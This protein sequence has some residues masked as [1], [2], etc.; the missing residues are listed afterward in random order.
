MSQIIKLNKLIFRKL[1]HKRIYDWHELLSVIITIFLLLLNLCISVKPVSFRQALAYSCSSSAWK[2]M[3]LITLQKIWNHH[4]HS[5]EASLI[6]QRCCHHQS[7]Q[8]LG[9]KQKIRNRKIFYNSAGMKAKWYLKK[10]FLWWM[11]KE[12]LNEIGND[13]VPGLLNQRFVFKGDIN[14][15]LK[16]KQSSI[17]NWEVRPSINHTFYHI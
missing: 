9:E 10:Y 2:I 16:V 11:E 7:F 5:L 13:V 15:C 12:R 3:G 4:R 6:P 17:C 1:I 8:T 14:R